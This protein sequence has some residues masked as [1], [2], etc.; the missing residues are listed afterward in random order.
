MNRFNH[1]VL[2]PGIGKIIEAGDAEPQDVAD[3]GNNAALIVHGMFERLQVGTGEFT[4]RLKE[5][6][7]R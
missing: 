1:L 2:N 7:V 6:R 5:R 3:G 4:N